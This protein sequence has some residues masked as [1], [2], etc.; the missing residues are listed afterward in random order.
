MRIQSQLSVVSLAVA[1]L[2]LATASTTAKADAVYTNSAAFAAAPTS[3]T[4]LGIA[5][6]PGYGSYAYVPS[7][8]SYGA[9]SVTYDSSLSTLNVDDAAYY[10]VNGGSPANPT[11]YLILFGNSP[12]DTLTINCPPNTAFSVELGGTYGTGEGVNIALSDGFSSSFT[13]SS[14][15]TSGGGP[16]FLGFTSSTPL[17]SATLTFND[18]PDY[19]TIDQIQYGAVTPEPSSLFLLGTGLIG[20]GLMSLRKLA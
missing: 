7:G 15:V 16:D 18:T 9:V 8:S 14:Y 2:L 4:T 11:N 10:T 1:A 13:L 20:L 17:T 3:V 6:S 12:T 5:P 19:G